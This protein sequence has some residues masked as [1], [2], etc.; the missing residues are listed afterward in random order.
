MALENLF[1]STFG[2]S[3]EISP[4]F[5]LIFISFIL[6]LLITLVYKYLTDQEL[7]KTLKDDVKFLQKK[8]KEFKDNPKK[9]ME[10]QK[11][12]MEKN[13]KYMMQS[14][15]PTL[16]T[17]IPLIFIFGWL[18]NRYTGIDLNLLFIHNWIWGYIIFS[19]IFSIILRKIL[20]VY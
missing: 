5:G 2:W 1:N 3:I 20:K 14:L 6:T 9:V 13:T 11:E 17:L 19:V 7:M 10:I 12:A 15:K 18:R 4:I 16:I 8:M